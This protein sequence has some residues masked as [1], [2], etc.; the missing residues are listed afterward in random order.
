MSHLKF[1]GDKTSAKMKSA[2]GAIRSPAPAE[3]AHHQL[4]ALATQPYLKLYPGETEWAESLLSIRRK[5][6]FGTQREAGKSKLQ[7]HRICSPITPPCKRTYQAGAKAATAILEQ[8]MS[9]V[10]SSFWFSLELTAPNFSNFV[11]SSEFPSMHQAIKRCLWQK[12]GKRKSNCSSFPGP[13]HFWTHLDGHLLEVLA[14]SFN[15]VPEAKNWA[16]R[17]S[18]GVVFAV[19]EVGV[20]DGRKNVSPRREKKFLGLCSLKEPMLSC[21]SNPQVDLSIL[22]WLCWGLFV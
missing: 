18:L 21:L 20:I 4:P 15:Y 1:S 8:H 16:K 7:S 5:E 6:Y 11:V 13:R 12:Q 9:N 22:W 3:M 14:S 17:V 10:V 2:S 19:L